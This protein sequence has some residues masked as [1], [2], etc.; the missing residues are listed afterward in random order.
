M[1]EKKLYGGYFVCANILF[2]LAA[3]VAVA[4]GVLS[5]LKIFIVTEYPLYTAILCG[6]IAVLVL[7]LWIWF[8]CAASGIRKNAK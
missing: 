3:L 7:V 1:K 8:L 5:Y 4:L 6:S 2:V